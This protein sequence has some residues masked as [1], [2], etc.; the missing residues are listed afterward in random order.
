MSPLFVL[1]LLQHCPPTATV[2]PP[3]GP[4][5]QFPPA[6]W[7]AIGATIAG[8]I[9]TLYAQHRNRILSIMP[10]ITFFR[11]RAANAWIMQ[12]FGQGTASN[13][14]FV[15]L[16][17]NN[18]PKHYISLNPLARDKQI[19]FLNTYFRDCITLIAKLTYTTGRK[20]YAICNS[21]TTRNPKRDPHPEGHKI[22]VQPESNFQTGIVRAPRETTQPESKDEMSVKRRGGGT[23]SKRQIERVSSR[24]QW[25]RRAEAGD[26]YLDRYRQ[27]AKSPTSSPGEAPHAARRGEFRRP[28]RADQ[29]IS[30]TYSRL[31][32]PIS[33]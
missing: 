9:A 6:A 27:L 23:Y 22:R 31:F 4:S 8:A 20:Y 11:D 17:A 21:E 5:W 19:L 13:I 26:L 12:N 24:Y 3:G 29:A 30:P 7:F 32:A 10:Q 33:R 15:E 28:F 1:A 14:T 2:T 25:V 16:D 18:V